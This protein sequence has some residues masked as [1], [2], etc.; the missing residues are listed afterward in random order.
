[1]D[2]YT[3][4]RTRRDIEAFADECPPREVIERLIDA[5]VWAPNHRMTEPWRFHVVAGDRRE[6]MGDAIAAWLVANGGTEGAGRSM[7][8]KL[9]RAPLTIL[10]SQADLVSQAG[11][12]GDATQALEDYAACVAGVQNL[13]LA[14][15][16]EGLIVH[17][18]T[19]R[20]ITYEGTRDYLGLAPG[21]RVVALLNVGYLRAG[22]PRK[23][24]SRSAPIVTWDW[25]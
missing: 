20:M 4:I 13:L 7:R 25:R 2:V 12:D 5:A 11:A 22:T 19:D 3:A 6:A 8:G 1:M 15:H 9:M 24:G 23:E 17:L 21:D 14:A 10:V 16:A 18:S